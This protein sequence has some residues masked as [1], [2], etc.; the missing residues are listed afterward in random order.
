ML[1]ATIWLTGCDDRVRNARPVSQLPPIYPDYVGVTIPC[2]IAP[3]CFGMMPDDAEQPVSRIDVTFRGKGAPLHVNGTYADIPLDEWHQLLRENSGD[4]IMVSVCVKQG[5][6]WLQ[7]RDFC[8]YVSPDSIDQGIAYRRVAP[9]YEYY[10]HMGFFERSLSTFD[11]RPILENS[12]DPSM[13]INCHMTNRGNPQYQTMHVRGPHDGTLLLTPQSGR[14]VLTTKTDST[15][16]SF[17]YPYWHPTG[18]YIAYSTNRTRQ[19]FH[20]R[21]DLRIEVADQASDVVVYHPQSGMILHS[22]LLQGDEAFETFPAFSPDGRTLYFCRAEARSLPAE[23]EQVKYSLC[24][25]SFDA[26]HG[27]FGDHIDTLVSA[28][29]WQGNFTFPRPSYDGRFVLLTRSDYGTFPIWHREADLWMLNL[30]THE[31]APVDVLNSPDTESYHSWSTSSRWVIFGSRRDDG[32]YTRLYISHIAPDGTAT[33]PFQLPQR[34][35]VTF[36]TESLYSYSVADFLTT[37]VRSDQKS[38]LQLFLG[39]E[40]GGVSYK[41]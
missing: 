24:S 8:I 31:V 7:Y 17:V 33:K 4:S 30:A 23:Y 3:L 9:G 36:Y 19:F 25:I 5:D 14:Q 41:Q 16:S 38:L 20:E 32:L 34:N 37:P 1:C 28:Q 29:Q 6:Q 13:C 22:P 18:H 26:E 12:S 15:L 10:G 2:N 35:P 27:A 21:R 11:E 39:K 40:R